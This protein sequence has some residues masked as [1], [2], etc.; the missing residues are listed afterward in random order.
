MDYSFQKWK[1]KNWKTSLILKFDARKL[2]W[3]PGFLAQNIKDE[4]TETN[5]PSKILYK[6]IRCVNN[7]KRFQRFHKT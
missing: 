5:Y 7:C 6:W 2:A 3:A 4:S 1:K